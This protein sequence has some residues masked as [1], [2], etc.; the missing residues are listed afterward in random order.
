MVHVSAI[1]LTDKAG[2]LKNAGH[3]NRTLPD[4]SRPSSQTS[5]GAQ[6]SIEG[7]DLEVAAGRSLMPA[8]D[9]QKYY[10]YFI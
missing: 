6:G 3:A 7:L 4:R 2:R 8:S 1:G 10:G 9:E 5:G